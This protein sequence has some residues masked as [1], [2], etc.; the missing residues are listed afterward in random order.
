MPVYDPVVI[1]TSPPMGMPRDTQWF[2][3][4][5]DPGQTHAFKSP[6]TRP[7]RE[8]N[9]DGLEAC[10]YSRA[11]TAGA[12]DGQWAKVVQPTQPTKAEVVFV[13]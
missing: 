8:I 1:A 10:F 2:G 6:T 3:S 11:N 13:L 5:I 9:N 12:L 7:Q 4:E